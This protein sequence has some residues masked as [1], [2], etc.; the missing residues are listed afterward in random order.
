VWKR[1]AHLH[2]TMRRHQLKVITSHFIEQLSASAARHDDVAISVHTNEL[3]EPA[4]A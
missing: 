3:H 2:D 1:I 4:A